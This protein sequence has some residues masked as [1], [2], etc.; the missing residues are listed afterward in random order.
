MRV[1]PARIVVD[2]SRMPT[3]DPFRRRLAMLAAGFAVGVT[4]VVIGAVMRSQWIVGLALA[5]MAG[6]ALLGYFWFRCPLCGQPIH[7]YTL[8]EARRFIRGSPRRCPFCE[9]EF[10]K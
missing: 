5:G 6:L 1:D 3:P 2:I 10:G 8:A 4:I 7:N 9:T